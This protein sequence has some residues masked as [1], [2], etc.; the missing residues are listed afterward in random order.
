MRFAGRGVA[1]LRQALEEIV[2]EERAMRS[3][4]L[5][6]IQHLIDQG[7]P[8]VGRDTG[9]LACADVDTPEDLR[10]VRQH[11]HLFQ[12]DGAGLGTAKLG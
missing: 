3:C 11:L 9:G 2:Q 10:F 1:L 4:F 7:H 5:D 8:V 6:S 12:Q